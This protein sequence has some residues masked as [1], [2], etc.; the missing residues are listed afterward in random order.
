MLS[1]GNQKPDRQCTSPGSVLLDLWVSARGSV[2]LW[3]VSVCTVTFLAVGLLAAAKTV[4]RGQA[5]GLMG[6]SWVGVFQRLWLHQFLTAPLMHGG[7]VHLLFNM[8]SLGMLGPE[9]EKAM[10]RGRYAA[11]SLLCAECSMIGFL[12][13]NW[14]TGNIVVGY[15]GVIFGILVAQAV[16]FPNNRVA[17]FGLFPLKMKHAAALLAA[18][19]LYLTI[20]PEGAGIAHAA[21]LFGALAAVVYLKGPGWLRAGRVRAATPANH[22]CVKRP[23]RVKIKDQIPREL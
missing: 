6:L 10:G 9:V 4:A 5:I 17:I 12:A 15:S 23:A 21:H 20:A 19:E 7:V 1:Q 8:L 22:A 2:S 14:G 3:L 18:V 13:F 16:F 11:F